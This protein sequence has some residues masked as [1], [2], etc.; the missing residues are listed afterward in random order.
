M[1]NHTHGSA[2][3]VKNFMLT[4]LFTDAIVLGAMARRGAIASD[5]GLTQ[6]QD[7]WWLQPL[8]VAGA[9][10]TLI[11][12]S[13]IVAIFDP[14][15]G[16]DAAHHYEAG[17]Y[18]SPLFSPNI[19]HLIGGA[20]WHFS[21]S[22]LVLWAPLAFR[23]TCY[24]YRKAYYRSFFIDPP[25]CAVGEVIKRNYHGER[26]FP[27]AISNF[28]RFFFYLAVVVLGFLWYDAY[29]AFF[30]D[31]GVGIGL[32]T[33]ILLANCIFLSFYTF[34]CHSFRHAVGGCLDCLATS[35][36]RH[37]LWVWV[38]KI[39]INHPMWAWI[40]LIVVT[41]ADVYVRLMA[42]G[43]ISAGFDRFI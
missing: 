20:W 5:I 31:D 39:N 28:H 7:S 35:K 34:S 8:S 29:A 10:G 23:G 4:S 37:K 33:I 13:L 11:V 1:R 3:I 21:P 2:W 14:G 32:G 22:I 18:L 17:P 36:K 12:Y 43:V 30:F 6:R 25:S 42:S 19:P 9:L 26:R 27:F 16:G 41:A 15:F 40:S 38:S 24:Y